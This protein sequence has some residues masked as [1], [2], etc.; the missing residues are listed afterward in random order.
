M[1]KKVLIC[2]AMLFFLSGCLQS[3]KS[4]PAIPN[5]PS[6]IPTA[7]AVVAPVGCGQLIIGKLHFGP[8]GTAL[9]LDLHNAGTNPIQLN[10]VEL[11]YQGGWHNQANTPPELQFQSYW[12]GE[13]LLLD[14]PD[15]TFFPLRH[16][17]ETGKASFSP[18]T[19]T[20]LRWQ[21][22]HSFA[23]QVLEDFPV[24][25]QPQHFFIWTD[26]FS[27]KLVYRVEGYPE[28][29]LPLQGETGA[30]ISLTASG[31]NLN[32]YSPFWLRVDV[33]ATEHKSVMV[34]LAVY[35]AVGRLVH[36]RSVAQ[37]LTVCLFGEESDSACT[38]RTPNQDEWDYNGVSSHSLIQDGNYK[39]VVLVSVE[40]ASGQP[41]STLQVFPFTIRSDVLP[42][43]P[44]PKP[45]A[46][47]APTPTPLLYFTPVIP[48]TL[49]PTATPPPP[50]RT[51]R[52]LTASS[53]P[54]IPTLTPTITRT[55]TTTLTLT[56][57]RSPTP[58]KTPTATY[59]PTLTPC[60]PVEMGG[61]Q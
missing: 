18:N 28:C 49:F 10:S 39:L 52:A 43:M 59:V 60:L 9:L 3:R 5:A 61:C 51:M 16:T 54:T 36:W 38:Y 56:P 41:L 19:Q 44:S 46:E 30:D 34:V 20:A 58:T 4:G 21:F 1:M 13:L 53:T 45:G 35:N 17:F 48:P 23:Q 24:L 32:I 14:P 8:D 37:K 25:S 15:S 27:G 29:T 22:K 57:Y 33:E 31:G 12:L 26:D 6:F 47:L 42:P 11:D 50:E 55:P 7:T 2:L 40:T